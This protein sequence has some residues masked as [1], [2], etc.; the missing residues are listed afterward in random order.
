MPDSRSQSWPSSTTTAA[1]GRREGAHVALIPLTMARAVANTLMPD[2]CELR[3]LGGALIWEG[4]L[5]IQTRSET[6][7]DTYTSGARFIQSYTAFLPWDAPTDW[8]RL[9]ITES[10]SPGLVDTSLALRGKPIDTSPIQ[11]SFWVG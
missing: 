11:Q 10:D 8:A 6:I 1:A 5:H 7:I 4:P 3:D 2:K 9:I